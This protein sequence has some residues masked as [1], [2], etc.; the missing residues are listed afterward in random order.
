[1]R[2][3]GTGEPIFANETGHNSV[4]RPTVIL[5][6]GIS[7]TGKTTIG[8]AL[9]NTLQL[10]FFAKDSIKEIL[11]DQLGTSDRAWSH[12]LSGVT[13]AVLNPILEEELRAGRGFV[14]ECNF[15][16]QYDVDKFR[17]WQA[18][19]DFRIVQVLCHTQGEVVFQ[20]FKARAESGTR[21]P[22]HVDDQNIEAFR[23]Y[24]MGGRC[25][26]LAVEG[27]VIE[28]DTTDFASVNIQDLADMILKIE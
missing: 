17:R 7:A 13:H 25:D 28:V 14:L 23:D 10:P 20:R 11:F 8:R 9:A 2:K 3:A 12:R 26:P 5:I 6:N 1:M 16:P 4:M 21:H 19:Y 22:G 24:L 27:T 15:N 18:S